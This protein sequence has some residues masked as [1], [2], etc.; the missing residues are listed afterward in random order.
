MGPLLPDDGP[1]GARL[2][3]RAKGIAI[4]WLGFLVVTLLLP[5]A[6]AIAAVVD[7]ALLV[8][9]RKT[10]MAVRL[11]LFCWWFLLGEVRF[12]IAL[13]AVQAAALGRDTRRRRR[14]VYRLRQ[15]L[16]AHHLA[17]ARVL[18]GLDIQVTGLE[19]VAPGPVVVL[20]RHSSIL[21]NALMDAIAGLRTGM[22]WRF[23]IKRELAAIPLF[24]IGG[25]MVPTAFV[26][27]GTGE[28]AA[29]LEQLRTL[30][31]DIGAD[32]GVVIYPEGTRATPEK[33]AAAQAI[34]R[35]RQPHVAPYA[36]RL[37]HLLPP[38]LGGPVALLQASRPADVVVCGHVGLDGFEYIRDIWA[39]GLVG[40]TIKLDFR[41]YDGAG[42]PA[43]TSDLQVWLYERWLELDEWVAGQA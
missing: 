23:V 41:R 30:A 11:V 43:G 37:R 2:Q 16:M 8:A 36:D 19:H 17:A 5:V 35:E 14:R 3:R 21:D 24:D 18:F 28:T 9:R 20:I 42:V 4:E 29:G 40:R 34:V 13:T 15:G 39:G 6:V 32:E 1:L 12:M 22:G 25:R 7:L 33:I 38:R 27:R 31:I 10:P 26:R